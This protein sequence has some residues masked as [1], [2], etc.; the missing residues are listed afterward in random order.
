MENGLVRALK[1]M[2]KSADE[3]ARIQ[4]AMVKVFV[5]NSFERIAHY[6]RQ[7]LAAVAEGDVLKRH[8]TALDTVTRFNPVNAIALRR[9][10]A[11]YVIARGKYSW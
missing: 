2:G 11:D 6:A 1:T 3:R 5:N 9:A 10:I 4:Q 8:L 7:A